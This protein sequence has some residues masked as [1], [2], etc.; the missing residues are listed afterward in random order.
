MLIIAGL[1]LIEV[2]VLALKLGS[3]ETMPEDPSDNG[4]IHITEYF[5][6]QC[7]YCRVAQ[8]TIEQ[9]KE[10]YGEKLEIEYKHF[11]L[12]SHTGAFLAAQA[13]ECAREQNEFERYHAKLFENQ[14]ALAKDDLLRYAVSL[15]LDVK[16][17][18]QCLDSQKTAQIVQSHLEDGQTKGVTG[19]PAF[20]VDGKS[21]QGAQPI[22]TFV[23]II[24]G[25]NSIVA[26]PKVVEPMAPIQISP[27]DDPSMGSLD[28]MVV[29]YEF[30]D[31]QCP[32]CKRFHVETFHQIKQEYIDT[33]KLLFV[34]KDLP[35]DF[36]AQAMPSAIAAQCAHEQGK[37]WG[38]QDKL[39][40]NQQ[41]LSEQLYLSIAKELG[42]DMGSFEACRTDGALE[43]QQDA[44]EASS[45]GISGTPGFLI[46]G[47]VVS[48]AMPYESFKALIESKLAEANP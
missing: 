14:N 22:E 6:Y 9:L 47:E 29:M 4:I 39:F 25:K 13:A 21:I 27:D 33:G 3:V 11:P 12:P 48:G 41:S 38:F 5:D 34:Y 16:K 36:H 45:A 32:Y 18:T 19:T 30:S 37:F 15:N 20:F 2:R 7:P 31:F 24:E 44:K 8:A 23:A 46:N 43:A 28:A 42:L 26:V 40:E 17:F 35:L 1:T 10:K